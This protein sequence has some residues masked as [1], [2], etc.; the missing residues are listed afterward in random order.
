M[1]RTPLLVLAVLL[2]PAPARTDE[3][4]LKARALRAGDTIAL[5]APAYP[6]ERP[7]V[8][9]YVRRLEAMGFKVR[10]PDNLFRKD[11]YLAGSDEERAA[12][13]NAAFRDP[14]VRAVFPCR[15]GY[16]LTRILDR[17]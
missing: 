15:G 8:D 9:A 5:V 11:H 6:I 4:W 14:D 2:G 7:K 10:V 3:P 17:L 1:N 12:E 16:G 13:L